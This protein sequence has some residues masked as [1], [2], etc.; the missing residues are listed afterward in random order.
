MIKRKRGADRQHAGINDLKKG[1]A[2]VY[3]KSSCAVRGRSTRP[4]SRVFEQAINEMLSIQRSQ[5]YASPAEACS[6]GSI[7]DFAEN[8]FVR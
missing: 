5:F 8:G 6:I 1:V 4:P 3:S 2:G 7:S